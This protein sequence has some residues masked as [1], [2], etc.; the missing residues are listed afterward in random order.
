MAHSF[1]SAC[2]AAHSRAPLLVA[3]L[4]FTFAACNSTDLAEPVA[5][6]DPL[7]TPATVTETAPLEPVSPSN[8]LAGI[9]MGHFSQP[10]ETFGLTYNGTLRTVS[11][12]LLVREL[13]AIKARGGRVVLAFAGNNRHFKD[14]RGHFSLS[15]W[16]SRI[17]RFRNVNFNQ[18]I[19]DGTIIGHY[20]MDEPNNYYNWNGTVVPG[21]TVEEMARYSK[22]FWPG[23]A[24]VV[25]AEPGYLATWAGTYRYLDAAWAQYVYRK[26]EASAYLTRNVADARRK[27]LALV[28]GLNISLGGPNRRP[29]TASQVA[30][31][32]SRMLADAYPCAFISWHYQSRLLE[33]STMQSAQATLR[34]LAQNRASKS[35]RS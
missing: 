32:G 3:L 33:T 26:G 17:D 5:S 12:D 31:W 13:A 14:S 24:T 10:T 34:R 1:Q 15:M 6:G 21:S 23:L 2:R 8:M 30:A 18:Y 7:A 27:G 19:N 11:P 28:V 9:P 35:C 25:R 29:M 22:Q 16:K 20:L 4:A